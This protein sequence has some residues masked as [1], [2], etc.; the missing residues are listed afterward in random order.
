MP[1]ISSKP[2]ITP[3]SPPRPCR[4]MKA[5]SMVR[6]W[7]NRSSLNCTSMAMASAPRFCSAANTALPL[8]REISRSA[9]SPPY[10]TPI[11]PNACNCWFMLAPLHFLQLAGSQV[12]GN[13]ADV[14][15][16][17]RH[18][19]VPRLQHVAEDAG[20][21]AGVVDEDRIDGATLAD[22]A[23]EAAAIGARNRFFASGID[24]HQ[25]Q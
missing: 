5:K 13:G 7:R 15:G 1:M 22:A 19:D 25:Q 8:R 9:D 14:A 11:L 3:S 21:L 4:A 6:N 18:D 17:L 20:N 16:A 24:F 2:W 12:C 10:N 23:A